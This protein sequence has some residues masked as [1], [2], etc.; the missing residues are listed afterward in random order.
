MSKR[1]RIWFMGAL[2]V[3]FV[4]ASIAA[5][6]SEQ[7]YDCHK[8]KSPGLAA[9]WK[10]S[11]HAANEVG[12]LECHEAEEGEIDGWT[13]EGQL[14]SSLVTPKDCAKCH[15]E[16]A[17][18]FQGSHHASAGNI[19]GSLDNVLGEIVEGAP[20]AH[21]GCWQ[22]HGS[23]IAF[24]SDDKGNVVKDKL[25]RPVLDK[26]TW[27]NSGI[28]RINP[29]GS[30]GTCSACHSRHRFSIEMARRPENCGKCHLGPD[31]PQKEIYEESK[32]GIAFRAADAQ[33]KMHMDAKPWI[34]GQTYTAAPTCATCHM[35]ATSD[36]PATHDPGK[37][38]SWTLRPK[39][40]KKMENWEQ[41]RQSMKN[42]C[43]ACHSNEWIDGHYEQYDAVV[44]LY[45]DK[46]GKPATEIMKALLDA[47][48]R[49]ATPFDEKIEWTFFYLWHHEGRRA[50]MGASMMAPDYTQWH[51]FYEIAERFYME[52]I[53]EA[54]EMAHGNR[55][56]NK[57]IKK[58]LNMP[59]HK[60]TQGMDEKT[61]QE[62]REFYK[63]RYE[64]EGGKK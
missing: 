50:R 54:K 23:K 19:L 20:A 13:H 38:I 55:K 64:K 27:P 11:V 22:C 44:N 6:Q 53:P 4:G 18:E 2:S 3:F 10:S 24:K 51:G 43:R 45:N 59:Q 41:K 5:A 35:S 52:L 60:W 48:L 25:G 7:C 57:V 14:I 56:V 61:K 40:S 33:G 58:V 21:A 26:T 36:Q 15:D 1:T 16:I 49:T 47:G 34:V 63:K 39:V 46:F 9:Q 42:V 29:D 8:V 32:H 31:H 30:V 17:E 28:G 37:R 62:I 12:C